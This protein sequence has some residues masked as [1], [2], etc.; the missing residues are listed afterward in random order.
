MKLQAEIEGQVSEVELKFDGGKAYARVDNRQYEIDTSEPEPGILLL[1]NEG[2][3]YEA[4]ISE[5]EKP[6]EPA[7]VSIRGSEF[8]ITIV[9]PK[10][11]RG[12]AADTIHD[13]GLAEIKTAMPGKVVRILVGVGETVEKDRGLIVVEAMKMQ[14]EIKS[15]KGGIV[16]EIRVSYG[17]TVNADEVLLIIE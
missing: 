6:G 7:Q 3:V 17:D 1:K 5:P 2:R 14:N 12:A 13:D 8:E 15:P 16:K 9:D 4:F 10:R 11:L